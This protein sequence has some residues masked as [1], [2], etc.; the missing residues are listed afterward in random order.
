MHMET[1]HATTFAASAQQL[2][3]SELTLEG[4]L[5]HVSSHILVVR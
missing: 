2:M 1:I 3:N 5:L 4:V